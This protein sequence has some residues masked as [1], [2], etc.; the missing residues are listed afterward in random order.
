M[1]EGPSTLEARLRTHK[2]EKGRFESFTR[3]DEMPDEKAHLHLSKSKEEGG[4]VE[5]N[6]GEDP[7]V[8]PRKFE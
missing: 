3:D 7:N 5:M 6:S 4:S 8:R 1:R 2:R